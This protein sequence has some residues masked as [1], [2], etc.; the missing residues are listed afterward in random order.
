M[1]IHELKSLF[2]RSLRMTYYSQD[3]DELFE[4]LGAANDQH[5]QLLEA[6]RE[7]DVERAME[8]AVNHW[9]K[10]IQVED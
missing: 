10:D 7:R 4:L 6:I 3:E 8:L 2:K 9:T 1:L 5:K